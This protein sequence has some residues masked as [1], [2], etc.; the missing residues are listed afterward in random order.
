ML[1]S[2]TFEASQP[3]GTSYRLGLRCYLHWASMMA[4]LQRLF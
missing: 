4:V 2:F 1:V 3:S